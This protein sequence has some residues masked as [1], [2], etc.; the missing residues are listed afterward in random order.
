MQITFS[1]AE[2]S[3]A[4]PQAAL[5]Q[6][7][8][9][10]AT[11]ALLGCDTCAAEF[12][13]GGKR[14][15]RAQIVLRRFGPLRVAWVP[16]GPLW[17][18]TPYDTSAALSAMRR[19]APM[20]ALWAIAADAPGPVSGLRAARGPEVAELDLT[21]DSMGRRAAMHGKWRNR[22]T[23]AEANGIDVIDR[24]LTL[25]RDAPLLKRELAQ[26]CA[27]RYAALPTAFTIAWLTAAPRQA[28]IF[29]AREERE[30]IAYIVVLLHAP[31]ATYHIG[32]S[33]TRG[34]SMSAHNLLIWRASEWL[35][36]RGYS[37]LDLGQIDAKRAPSLARFKTGCGAKRRAIG[38][39]ML[40]F[41]L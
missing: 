12:H 35:A 32:W 5:Q 30:V 3:A 21:P 14:I 20:R 26:R 11:L 41:R 8:S 33:G 15:G 40:H 19:T 38:P 39:T 13:T 9:Y 37:R 36:A 27:R 1:P 28:Q 18:S 24:P 34:R 22:L 31:V 10:A 7:P 17:S 4:P 23:R 25:P 16:R 6:H 29:A 2:T